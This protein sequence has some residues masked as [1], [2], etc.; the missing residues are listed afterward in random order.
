M[1]FMGAC[2]KKPDMLLITEFC[3]LGSLFDLLVQPEYKPMDPARK[4]EMA[5]GAA[6]GLH[7]LHSQTILHRD[8]KVSPLVG[9]TDAADHNHAF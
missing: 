3:E 9:Q 7:Y 1:T 6:Q 8:F 5:H 4:M 2:L